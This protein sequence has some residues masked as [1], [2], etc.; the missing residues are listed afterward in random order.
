M[1]LGSKV[2]CGNDAVEIRSQYFEWLVENHSDIILI[3]TVFEDL[4]GLHPTVKLYGLMILAEQSQK[5]I[6]IITIRQLMAE[7]RDKFGS[8][9][10]GKQLFFFN[11]NFITLIVNCVYRRLDL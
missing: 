10:L 11:L 7:A 8:T 5:K 3:R 2:E 4:K 9:E 6:R 1:E